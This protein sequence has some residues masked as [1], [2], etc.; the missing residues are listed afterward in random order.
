MLA[1]RRSDKEAS[2]AK[3]YDRD[4]NDVASEA[5]PGVEFQVTRWM[6]GTVWRQKHNDAV[7]SKKHC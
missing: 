2:E 3:M 4:V 1:A 6:Q 5:L 7:E